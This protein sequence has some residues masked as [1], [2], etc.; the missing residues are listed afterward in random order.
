[1][2]SLRFAGANPVGDKSSLA[3]FQPENHPFSAGF[4][5]PILDL[6]LDWDMMLGILGII[7]YATG[8][9]EGLALAAVGFGYHIIIG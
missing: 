3:A 5:L 4:P 6:E 8:M 2:F 1:M 7:L 9:P